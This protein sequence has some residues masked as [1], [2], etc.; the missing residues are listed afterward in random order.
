MVYHL[1]LILDDARFIV[2]ERVSIDATGKGAAEK[3]LLHHRI[4]ARDGP[5]VRDGDVRIL[6]EACAWAALLGEAATRAG[7]V[8]GFAFCVHVLAEALLR[9]RH[10]RNVRLAGLVT[11]PQPLL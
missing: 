4:R 5:V 8:D 2:E 11:D 1:A 3:D 9:V 7:H 6:G 10:A